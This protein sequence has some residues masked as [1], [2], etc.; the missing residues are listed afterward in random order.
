MGS[1]CFVSRFNGRSRPRCMAPRSFTID[2]INT[3]MIAN[4]DDNYSILQKRRKYHYEMRG[5]AVI[6]A[7]T[8][9]TISKTHLR[10]YQ[11]NN[12]HFHLIAMKQILRPFLLRFW[13]WNNNNINKPRNWW[14]NLS[15]FRFHLVF[16]L[17][18]IVFICTWIGSDCHRNDRKKR[19]A[20][21]HLNNVSGFCPF[22]IFW[23]QFQWQPIQ[24][25]FVIEPLAL[26]THHW[27]WVVCEVSNVMLLCFQ[28]ISIFCLTLAKIT[29]QE[30]TNT[31]ACCSLIH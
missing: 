29:K 14:Q 26:N 16:I 19:D 7:W 17:V 30:I 21:L 11:I 2:T 27:H 10:C 25:E 20:F 8:I 15:L 6:I 4:L 31:L 5:I 18:V 23:A 13:V 24:R 1:I 9:E 3:T 12:I 28:E 22:R